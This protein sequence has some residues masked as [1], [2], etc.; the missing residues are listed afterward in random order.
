MA[1]VTKQQLTDLISDQVKAVLNAEGMSK[2][3]DAVNERIEKAVSPL[4]AEA[5]DWQAKIF[6]A[7]APKVEGAKREAGLAF[8]RIVRAI[9]SARKSGGGSDAVAKTLQSWGDNDLAEAQTKALAASVASDGGYLVAPQYSQDILTARRAKVIVR[10]AGA[11]EYP[12]PTGTLHLPKVATG[13]T[14]GYIGENANPTHSNP[15][16]GE[17]ILT[18]KKL[19]VTSAISN[20]LLRYN[21]P[22]SDA[23]VRDDIVRSLAVSEDAAFIRSQGVGGEPKGLRY[24]ASAGNIIAANTVSVANV[25]A[26]LGKSIYTMLDNNVP[27]TKGAWLLSPRSHY[28]LITVRDGIG[29]FAFRPE[30][31]AGTLFGYPFFVTTSIPRNLTVGAN[32][33][34]SEVYFVNFDDVVIGD[35]QRL[36]ID[37]SSEAAYYN[38]SSVVAAFSLDQTVIRAIAEHDLVVRDPNAVVVLTGVRW[39]V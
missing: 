4:R 21:S 8:G 13:V 30:M 16:F 32:A 11:V 36:L 2:V 23:I 24:W 38:G 1:E 19:A 10:Q 5:T 18:W 14:G 12:M 9:A 33:D 17:N 31:A 37:V 3:L 29:N 34:C 6:G 28:Y 22:Q 25:T 15:V 27:V 20:D 39:G 7:I 26:D 35:S